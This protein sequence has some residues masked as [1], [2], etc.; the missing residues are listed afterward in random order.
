MK[1]S[2]VAVDIAVIA[3]GHRRQAAV[4]GLGF[5][6]GDRWQTLGDR[7]DLAF[8]HREPYSPV[9]VQRRSRVVGK[10]RPCS[11]FACQLDIVYLPSQ[12][13]ASRPA[14]V[15]REAA[16]WKSHSQQD[17]LAL[18]REIAPVLRVGTVVA[19][20]SWE[21]KHVPRP[22]LDIL[23]APDEMCFPELLWVSMAGEV[24]LWTGFDSVV[25]DCHIGLLYSG[26][27]NFEPADWSKLRCRR[28]RRRRTVPRYRSGDV[29]RERQGQGQ[30]QL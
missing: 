16:T 25:V 4:P 29:R 27:L 24:D 26:P 23:L 22:C 10:P 2:G 8:E 11:V 17:G 6:V 19:G 30:G 13:P 12:A 7:I 1:A 21:G 20:K 3:T 18:A 14:E 5:P 9:I 28:S 15:P